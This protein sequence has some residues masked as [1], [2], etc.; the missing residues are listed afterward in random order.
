MDNDKKK[1]KKISAKEFDELNAKYKAGKDREKAVNLEAEY[2]C[3][4]ALFFILDTNDFTYA[5]FHSVSFINHYET[6]VVSQR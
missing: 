1:A 6:T 3:I 4:K 5:D 2:E